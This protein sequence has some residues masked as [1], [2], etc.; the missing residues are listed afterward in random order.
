VWNRAVPGGFFTCN[1]KI[2]Q[3]RVWNVSNKSS[4]E[5]IKIGSSGLK[6]MI[7]LNDRDKLFCSF[8]NGSVGILDLKKRKL[9]Y[10]TEPGHA[11]TIFDIKFNPKD[12][13]ILA[14]CSYDGTIKIWDVLNSKHIETLHSD[15]LVAGQYR[16]T[17]ETKSIV[18]G[19]AWS[20]FSDSK[21]V[22][23]TAKGQI[24]LFD[25]KKSKL[26]CRY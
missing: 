24:L 1:E 14:T 15:A 5:I 19:I 10:C 25:Y 21:L 8:T 17:M 3:I 20:S 2:A 9:E 11:E 23:C 18:Y 16:G 22:A 12:H 6:H 4:A 13:N 26:L 7:V